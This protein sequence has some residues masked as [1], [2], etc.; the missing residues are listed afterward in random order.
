MDPQLASPSVGVPF[1]DLNRLHR[2]LGDEVL[3]AVANL[4][5]TSAFT[6]GPAVAEFERAFAS[7]CGT[8]ECIGVA[9]GLDGL[10]LALRAA[11]VEPGDEVIV[12]AHTFV[13]TV[14]AVAQAGGTPILADIDEFDYGLSAAATEPAITS[15][16]RFLL[17]VHLYGQMADMTALHGLAAR[18]RLSVIEDAC[19]AHG[20]SR[21]GRRAGA[22]GTAAAFSFYPAKNLGAFGDAGAVVPDDADVAETVRALREHGQRGKYQHDLEGYTARLDTIQ[23]LVLAIKLPLLDEWN[24]ERRTAARYYGEQ[25]AGVGDLVLPHVPEGSNPVWHLYVVRA[26]DPAGLAERLAERGVATGRHYPEAIHLSRAFAH[27]GNGV[28]LHER[29]CDGVLA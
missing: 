23:A 10:V 2:T 19:Q 21:D 29:A 28:R 20:A 22:T 8:E 11:G 4:I 15:R 17:P 27:L 26:A 14:A 6:N 9:S 25:L 7:Y 3:E 18:H 13:A 24:E 1:V 5:E 12:P 16:T